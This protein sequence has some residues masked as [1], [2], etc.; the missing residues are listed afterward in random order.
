M[1]GV[2]ILRG[3]GVVLGRGR[4]MEEWCVSSNDG[5]EPLDEQEEWV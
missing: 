4:T 1:N 3:G 2:Q 5:K